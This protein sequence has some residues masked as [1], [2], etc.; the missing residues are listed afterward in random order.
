MNLA[1]FRFYEELNEFLPAEKRKRWFTCSFSGSPSVK[2]TIEALGVPH[3]EVDL[4]LVNG[5]SVDFAYKLR[6]EDAVSVYPVFEWLD[7]SSVTHLREKPL[8]DPRFILDVHL[9]K[10]AKYMRLCGLDTY[11]CKD[12][13]DHEIISLSLSEKRIILTRD[14]GILK[15][16]QVTHGYWIRSK[17]PGEQLAEVL[18]R[19]DLKDR[20]QPFRRCMECNGFLTDVSKEDIID[21]LQPGTIKFYQTFK[22]CCDCDH[23]Y[24]EGSHY[25]RMRKY[26]DSLIENL[27][28]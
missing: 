9:G 22:K 12:Y 10:L 17:Y 28:S 14:R 26:I 27:Y 5:I 13:E 8:R 23:I 24:W 6:N 3:V 1:R 16:K 7:I 25:G 2:D 20:I 4:I 15:N 19:F 11:Y 21:R 18:K